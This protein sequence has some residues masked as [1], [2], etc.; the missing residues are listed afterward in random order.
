M[1]DAAN[2]ELF[3]ALGN[4]VAILFETYGELS[5]ALG[6]F[7][8]GEIAILTAFILSAQGLLSF[9]MVFVF[10]IIGF[11][12]ADLFWY[13]FGRFILTFLHQW[14]RYEKAA[15]PVEKFLHHTVGRHLFLSLIFIKFLYGAR[16]IVMVYLALKKVPFR[17]FV[18]FDTLGLI[19]FI[20]I[21]AVIGWL[22]GR[23]IYN[24]LPAYHTF[25]TIVAA[26]VI[27]VIIVY[28]IRFFLRRIGRDVT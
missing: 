2:I 16:L 24:L 10:S 8:L 20:G 18:L 17:V 21:L 28:A 7:L 11:L 4:H 25:T 22:V 12:C 5:V 26:V 6:A 19:I 27:S 14:E 15:A 13:L 9:E 23:G 3:G 1:P